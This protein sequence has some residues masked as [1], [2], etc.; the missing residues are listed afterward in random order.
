M[1]LFKLTWH[2]GDRYQA[3]EVLGGR[4][5]ILELWIELRKVI[6]KGNMVV[7]DLYGHKQDPAKGRNGLVGTS[8]SVTP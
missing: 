1:D 6:P 5:A 3:F 4:D 8:P 7:H 2:Q